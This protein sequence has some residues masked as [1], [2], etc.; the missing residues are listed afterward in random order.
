M[1][2]LALAILLALA[3]AVAFWVYEWWALRRDSRQLTARQDREL[4][5]LRE[6]RRRR[7]ENGGAE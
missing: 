3:G 2:W 7:G 5:E 4:R 1:T 6:A